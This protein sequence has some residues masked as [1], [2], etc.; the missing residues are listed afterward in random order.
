M[1]AL[2]RFLEWSGYVSSFACV[3]AAVACWLYVPIVGRNI[4]TGLLV[5]AAG[6]F[7]VRGVYDD[8][9]A[10]ERAVWQQKLEV[11]RQRRDDVLQ[12]AQ[13]KAADLVEQLHA[14]ELQKAS[15]LEGI[16]NAS[17]ADDGHACLD[18]DGLRRLNELDGR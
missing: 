2:I 10:V 15:K 9:V 7:V 4:A 18:P 11:E 12:E 14:I 3:A 8:G 1:S 6:L 17:R 16:D 13:R 5:A